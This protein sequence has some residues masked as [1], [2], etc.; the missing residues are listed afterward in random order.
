MNPFYASFGPFDV[1]DF[2]EQAIFVWFDQPF[3]CIELITY[4]TLA[5]LQ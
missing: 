2:M 4:T 1:I 5:M 3:A